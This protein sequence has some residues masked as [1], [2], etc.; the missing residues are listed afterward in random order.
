MRAI[1]SVIVCSALVLPAMALLPLGAP[2]RESARAQH[3]P[4]PPLLA[5]TQPYV[6][7][8]A[9][10]KAWALA[11][12]AL[13]TESN[14]GRHDLLGGSERTPA[15]VQS[16]QEGL[17]KWW[18]THN[19]QELLDTLAWI[20]EGGHR[21][22]FD[23]MARDLTNAP[24]ATIAMI[25]SKVRIDASIS[26]RVEI[27]LK[28]GTEFGPKSIVAWDF[29]R[30]VALCGWGYIAGYLTEDEAWERIMPAARLVQSTFG[31]WAELGKNHVTGREF[32]SLRQTQK[33]GD[34]T[35]QNYQKLLTDPA[36][37]WV[38]IP[39]SLDLAPPKAAK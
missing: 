5:K 21:Q 24:P 23:D 17:A 1:P 9:E 11:T 14:R 31:S 26:N 7:P 8:T 2:P 28:Y 36:S 34:A 25:R 4:Y 39:W 15:E 37:P 35:R 16:W 10:Q 30:Y 38:R 27:V 6:S 29:D 12:C 13:L 22:E 19:R 3:H 18:D 32:W 20:E 33:N